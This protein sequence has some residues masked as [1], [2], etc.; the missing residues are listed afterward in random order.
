MRP[1]GMEA[2]FRKTSIAWCR[3]DGNVRIFAVHRKAAH[4]VGGLDC[5]QDAACVERV[6]RQPVRLCV[7]AA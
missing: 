4:E 6:L 5:L 2:L 3:D 1:S 7:S